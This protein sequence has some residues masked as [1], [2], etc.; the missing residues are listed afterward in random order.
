MPSN[1]PGHLMAEE[2]FTLTAEQIA[3]LNSM[4]PGLY[5]VCYRCRKFSP[6]SHS[7]SIEFN[8]RAEVYC[9]ACQK[10]IRRA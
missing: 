10:G 6:A 1:I 9:D 2:P 5:L 3:A 7:L 4:P 8:G